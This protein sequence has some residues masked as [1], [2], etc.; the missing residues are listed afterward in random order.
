MPR[1]AR[2]C[3]APFC[4]HTCLLSAATFISLH[5]II[6]ASSERKVTFA[7]EEE[8]TAAAV[9]EEVDDIVDEDEVSRLSPPECHAAC[10]G[11]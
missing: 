6:M 8:A 5:A 9:A 3:Q 1:R 4:T 10:T 7:E 2:S 11:C